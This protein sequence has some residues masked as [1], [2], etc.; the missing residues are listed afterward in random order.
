M[1]AGQKNDVA[2]KCLRGTQQ[3]TRRL[4]F[5]IENGINAPCCPAIGKLSAVDKERSD[6]E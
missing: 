4:A 6:A 3:E 1:Q 2:V 5:D